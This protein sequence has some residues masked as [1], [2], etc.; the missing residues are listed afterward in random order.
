MSAAVGETK[1]AKYPTKLRRN[2]PRSRNGCLTCRQRKKK[3]DEK[4]P[5]CAGCTRNKLSCVWPARAKTAT[6]GNGDASGVGAA[7]GP[8]LS[9][10][11]PCQ[12]ISSSN[13]TLYQHKSRWQTYLPSLAAWEGVEGCSVNLNPTYDDTGFRRD[14]VASGLASAGTN[15]N[16]ANTATDDTDSVQ[17]QSSSQTDLDDYPTA[18]TTTGTTADEDDDGYGFDDDENDVR[19]EDDVYL[20]GDDEDNNDGDEEDEDA[21]LAVWSPVM[22][23]FVADTSPPPSTPITSAGAYNRA[24]RRRQKQQQQ[25]QQQQQ[26][27]QRQQ[28]PASAPRPALPLQRRRVASMTPVSASMLRHYIVE[29]A[30]T[31]ATSRAARNPYIAAFLPLAYTDD[32][33]MHCVLAIGGAHL[34]NRLTKPCAADGAFGP[35]ALSGSDGSG[36]FFSSS[37]P[38]SSSSSFPFSSRE[39]P[40]LTA[41]VAAGATLTP[42][43]A[44]DLA[45]AALHE[46]TTRHYSCILRS[47]RSALRDLQPTDGPQVLRVLA[48][49]LLLSTYECLSWNITGGGVFAHLRASRQLIGWLRADGGKSKVR[50]SPDERSML[51]AL[52]EIYAYQVLVNRICPDGSVHGRSAAGEDLADD[53]HEDEDFVADPSLLQDQDCFGLLFSGLHGLFALIPA[54]NRLAAAAVKPRSKPATTFASSGR[55]PNLPPSSLSSLFGE[56][57]SGGGPSSLTIAAQVAALRNRALAWQLPATFLA[58]ATG[59]QERIWQRAIGEVYR[60][61]VLI[62]IETIKTPDTE[63]DDAA[64]ASIGNS[65]ATFQRHIHAIGEAVLGADLVASRFATILL[66]PLLI[67]G[68]I[69]VHPDER[70]FL[71]EGL[72]ASP[73]AT[74]SSIRAADM[75]EK[76]WAR[77]DKVVLSRAL[78][79]AATAS[80]S[81]SNGTGYSSSN[82]QYFGPHGLAQIMRETNVNLCI[83]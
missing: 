71:A 40:P 5:Q 66:W 62:Y 64:P 16:T 13:L 32:L 67:A 27:S 74:W 1:T 33:V 73:Q 56:A 38:S 37:S 3:C 19:D 50:L 83:G 51:G 69:L 18:T 24:R 26:R 44:P 9:G 15:T 47:L 72:R 4:R 25:Q 20:D 78:A 36:P 6:S 65:A 22:V 57:S 41:N 14:A 63:D 12:Y 2:Q 49:L 30:P 52:L 81:I 80:E 58:Q 79:S 54:V 68:S 11:H 53:D 35:S 23:S 42:Y 60:H 61:G 46:A 31:L 82:R 59:D 70:I 10:S 17:P 77:R 45:A 29:A 75:L 7:G 43:T 8:S 28:R 76:L 39:G 34:S 48:V 55:D 21:I